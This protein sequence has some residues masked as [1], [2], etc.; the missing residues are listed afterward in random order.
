M[1]PHSTTAVLARPRP[2]LKQ[3][4]LA[5]L[6]MLKK[7]NESVQNIILYLATRRCW[8]AAEVVVEPT[9]PAAALVPLPPYTNTSHGKVRRAGHNQRSF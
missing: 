2:A 5:D 9:N 8:E 6:A 4:L 1:H 7:A 3:P